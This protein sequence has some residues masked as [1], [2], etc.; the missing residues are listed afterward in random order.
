MFEVEPS[1]IAIAVDGCAMPTFGVPLAVA[2]RFY[3]RLADVETLGRWGE[4][5]HVVTSAMLEF[6]YLV[7]GTDRFDTALMEA[8]HPAI[9]SKSGAE[10]FHALT[11]MGGEW[12]MCTKVIDGA[13]RAVAPFV[14]DALCANGILN[15]GQLET[16]RAFHTPPVFNNAH[17]IVGNL[18]PAHAR[19]NAGGER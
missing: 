3:A 5:A 7:A 8:A 4:A 6:P 15:G 2:A 19:M 10:G 18:E 13:D 12:G 1:S 9:V 11:W 14:V 17:E 16:L